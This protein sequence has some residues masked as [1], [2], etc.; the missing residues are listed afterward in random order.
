MPTSANFL[1]SYHYKLYF[2]TTPYMCPYLLTYKVS[3][4][5]ETKFR[6]EKVSESTIVR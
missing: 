6:Q 3:S 1:E 2:S 4:I 5:I